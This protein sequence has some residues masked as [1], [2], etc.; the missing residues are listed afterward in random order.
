MKK[1]CVEEIYEL[2]NIRYAKIISIACI[3]AKSLYLSPFAIILNCFS[4]PLKFEKFVASAWFSAVW[5][6]PSD[7]FDDVDGT[8]DIDAFTIYDIIKAT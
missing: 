6:A 5:V 4:R 8:D 3:C 7:E 2:K 1:K